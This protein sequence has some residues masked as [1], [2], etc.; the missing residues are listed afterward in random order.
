MSR[1]SWSDTNSR[2]LLNI[3][4]EEKNKG[5]SKYNWANIAKIFNAQTGFFATGKQVQTHYADMK[6]KYKCWEELQ[7]LT[8]ISYDPK[9]GELD[10][11]EKSLERY[12]GFLERNTKYGKKLTTQKL[13]N[14]DQLSILFS[15]KSA[16]GVGGC[17]SPSMGKGPSYLAKN[18]EDLT[19]GEGRG[20][21]ELNEEDDD[22]VCLSGDENKSPQGRLLRMS[23]NLAPSKEKVKQS[24]TVMNLNVDKL[25]LIVLLNYCQ[26][27]VVLQEALRN[28]KW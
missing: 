8:G 6:E 26:L 10:V 22:R 16:H 24:L 21:I 28:L 2:K 1:I 23:L 14:L 12:K 11:A 27:V 7:S 25:V 9:T 18:I 15:G 4:V 5:V 20:D 19:V 17:F 13:E 3:I